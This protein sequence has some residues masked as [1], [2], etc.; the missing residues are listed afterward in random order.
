MAILPFEKHHKDGSVWAR[1]Q[2]IDGVPTGYWEWFRTNGTRLRSG[3]FK[4]GEQV[5]EWTTYDRDGRPYK[6]TIMTPKRV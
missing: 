5:G 3:H 2:T 6:V 1:G 4:D